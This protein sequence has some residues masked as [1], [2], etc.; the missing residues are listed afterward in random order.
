MNVELTGV[1]PAITTPFAEDGALDLDGFRTLVEA[2]IGDGVHGIVVAGCTGES[3]ALEDDE[4]VRLFAAAVDQAQGR[5]PIVAGCGAITSAGAIG[6]ARAAENAGCAAAMIQPPWYVIPGEAEVESYYRRIIAAGDIPIMLYNIPRRTGINMSADLVD[7]LA[8]EPRVVALKES[9]K[10]WLVLSAMIRRVRDRISVL[11]GY[12][13]VLG[14][15]AISEGA[16]GYVDSTTPVIGR[17]SRQFFD[18]AVSGDMETARSFEGV[19]ATLKFFDCGTFPATVKVALEHLGRPGGPPR[20]PIAPLTED[21]RA[22]IRAMLV[23]AGLL[24]AAARRASAGE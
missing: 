15:A 21:Q 9:S 22:R 16:V 12:A 2:V 23:D 18:A 19:M 1:I 11:A 8:D 5:V 4:R 7:R 17:L 6:H 13:S 3:W 14:L 20:D 10:D 24:P